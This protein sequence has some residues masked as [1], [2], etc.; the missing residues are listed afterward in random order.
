MRAVNLLLPA[1]ARITPL[2]RKAAVFEYTV[3][4]ETVAE[5]FFTLFCHHQ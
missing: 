3:L 2:K 4:E 5:N 1:S